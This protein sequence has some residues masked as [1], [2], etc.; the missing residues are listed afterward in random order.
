MRQ[1]GKRG[2]WLGKKLL[3]FTLTSIFILN[4]SLT[5]FATAAP[6]TGATSACVM[7]ADSGRILYSHN[8][9]EERCIASITKIMTAILVIENNTD[10]DQVLTASARAE[11]E[12]GTSLYLVEGDKLTLRT[13]LYGTMLRSGNDAAVAIAEHTGGTVEKF[14]DMMNAKA[15]EL[16]MTHSHFSWPNGLIDE[17]NYSSA[18]DMA[19]L[20]RY[21]MKNEFFAKIVRTGYIETDDGY[22]IENHNKLLSRDKRCIGIKTGFTTL[23]GRTLVTCFQDPD[24]D[25]RVII[26]TLNDYDHYNDHQRLCDW[27]FENFTQ[28]TLVKKGDEIASVTDDGTKVSLVAKNTFT[29]P[30]KNGTAEV[31]N[32][33]TTFSVQSNSGLPMEEGKTAGVMRFYL[34]GKKIG[35]T[36]LTYHYPTKPTA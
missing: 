4:L 8:E 7:D 36:R 23:A 20:A 28:K 35:A 27:A 1:S 15:K 18:K 30:E 19:I 34:N 25:R 3:F 17:D 6:A 13:G 21:A 24:S 22:Q 32:I 9:N 12:D 16:G 11:A 10:F 5:A 26:V 29:W 31:A 14:V 33:K 2:K